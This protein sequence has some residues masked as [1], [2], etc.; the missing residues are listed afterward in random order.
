M[1]RKSISGMF[2]AVKKSSVNEKHD[3]KPTVK[4]N[5]SDSTE[6]KHYYSEYRGSSYT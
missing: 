6:C 1:T 4:S 2:V 5:P 3:N